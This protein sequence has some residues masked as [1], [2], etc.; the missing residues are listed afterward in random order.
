M[1]ISV[2]RIYGHI[3]DFNTGMNS[4]SKDP[5]RLLYIMYDLRQYEPQV[6]LGSCILAQLSIWLLTTYQL[7]IEFLITS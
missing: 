6:L 3:P 2:G 1:I 7:V 5:T 4:R